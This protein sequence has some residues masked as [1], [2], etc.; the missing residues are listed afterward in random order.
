MIERRAFPRLARDWEIEFQMSKPE[1]DQSNLL[2]GGLHDLGAGGFSFDSATACPPETLFQFAIKPKDNFKPMVGVAR[3]AWT[4][5]R[6][7]FHENGAQFIWVR[8]IGMDPQT[9]VNPLSGH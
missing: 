7:G 6:E 8:W 3:V 5:G 9:M 4:R 2:N 1:S